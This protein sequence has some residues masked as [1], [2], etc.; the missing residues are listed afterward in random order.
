MTKWLQ[1]LPQPPIS[2]G[3]YKINCLARRALPR[4]GHVRSRRE[5]LTFGR[6]FLK[7]F[8]QDMLLPK[9]L[10]VIEVIFGHTLMRKRGGVVPWKSSNKIPFHT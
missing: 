2:H 9:E 6:D 4:Q 3:V 8:E 10:S 1:I 5:M 7:F